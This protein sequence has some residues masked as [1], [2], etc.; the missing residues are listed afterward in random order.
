MLWTMREL[1]TLGLQVFTSAEKDNK[2]HFS[3]S[4]L[5]V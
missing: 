3:P 4:K 1:K 5:R 2:M